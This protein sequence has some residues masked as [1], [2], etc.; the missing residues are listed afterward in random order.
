MHYLYSKI[1]IF[2]FTFLLFVGLITCEKS[3]HEY[4]PYVPV[5]IEINLYPNLEAMG[6]GQTA[7]I[8]PDDNNNGYI[9]INDERSGIIPLTSKVFGN[10][11]V[12]YRYEK[13]VFYAY[14]R[15]CTFQ[16][17]K[18]CAVEIDDSGWLASCP[19]CQSQ[20]IITFNGSPTENSKAVLPLKQYPTRISRGVL[21]ISN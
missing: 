18:N 13:Q 1:Q 6:I 3:N 2:L 8:L 17:S 14:D 19:C 12:I 20:F 21:Y 10:G 16:P 15:T 4:V 11:I 5:D 7:L 9:K